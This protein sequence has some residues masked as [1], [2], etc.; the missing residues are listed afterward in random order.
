MGEGVWEGDGVGV[1]EGDGTGVGTGIGEGEKTDVGDAVDCA[2]VE[3]VFEETGADEAPERDAFRIQPPE[4][5]KRNM[6]HA[7]KIFVMV[8]TF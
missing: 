8:C 2:S 1:E 4:K 7:M 5:A 3:G 6:R